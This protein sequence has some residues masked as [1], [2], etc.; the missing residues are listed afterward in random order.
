MGLCKMLHISIILPRD[1]TRPNRIS[2]QS[3]VVGPP[4]HLDADRQRR[5]TTTTAGAPGRRPAEEGTGGT[6]AGGERVMIRRPRSEDAR[7]AGRG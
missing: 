5:D 6:A 2:M 7:S 4:E 1:N 3:G